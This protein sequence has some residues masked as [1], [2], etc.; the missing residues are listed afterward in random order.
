MLKAKTVLRFSFVA[1]VRSDIIQSIILTAKSTFNL[2]SI[3]NHDVPRLFIPGA[4]HC[5]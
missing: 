1:C 4:L 5:G 2:T 3:V